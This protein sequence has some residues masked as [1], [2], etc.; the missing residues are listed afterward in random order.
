M[1]SL[2]LQP[3]SP[4]INDKTIGE[5]IYNEILGLDP[6]ENRVEI[7]MAGIISMTTYCAK[8]IF[9]K[10]YKELGPNLFENNIIL[11]KVSS[12]VLLIIKMGIKNAVLQ[13][14]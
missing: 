11:K 2:S 5:R 8:Q 7:D 12:D 4:I 6:K 9:G 13:Q 3:Y 1:K 10:L 14:A